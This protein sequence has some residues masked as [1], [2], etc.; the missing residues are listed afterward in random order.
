MMV[1]WNMPRDLLRL[2]FGLESTCTYLRLK[3]K[4]NSAKG[5]ASASLTK[6][7]AVR[8]RGRPRWDA[9]QPHRTSAINVVLSTML[10]SIRI[11]I[12]SS[13]S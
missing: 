13:S 1:V 8:A 10:T 2:C 11:G 6:A 7:E 12:F 4:A 5:R 3:A 9:H